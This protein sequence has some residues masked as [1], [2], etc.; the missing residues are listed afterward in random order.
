MTD[1][2]RKAILATAVDWDRISTH[3]EVGTLPMIQKLK[4][5]FTQTR[6]AYIYRCI[7]AG[8]A[9]AL[10]YGVLDDN[11]LVAWLG[12]SAV[13]LNVMPVANTPTK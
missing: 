12:F 11:E 13:V 5:Q 4:A 7:A 2:P 8:G 6:R 10:F 1:G 3:R 9:V